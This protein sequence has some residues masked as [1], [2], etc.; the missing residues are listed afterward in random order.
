MATKTSA[1]ILMPLKF[2]GPSSWRSS[3]NVK[4]S[5]SWGDFIIMSELKTNRFILSSYCLHTKSS[6]WILSEIESK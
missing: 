6:S 2:N 3:R 4:F 5:Y 1:A